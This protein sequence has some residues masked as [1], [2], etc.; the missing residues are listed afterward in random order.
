M[1]CKMRMLVQVPYSSQTKKL[2]RWTQELLEYAFY[3]SDAAKPTYPANMVIN[4]NLQEPVGRAE[5]LF[6]HLAS[7]WLHSF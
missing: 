6:L 3:A 1:G 4:P 7:S 2:P 5:L